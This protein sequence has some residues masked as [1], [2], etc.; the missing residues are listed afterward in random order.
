MSVYI[1]VDLR[2]RVRKADRDRCAYCLTVETISGISLSFDHI[3]PL[4]KGG[5]TDFE[6]LCLSCRSCNEFKVDITEAQD[7]LTG[8]VVNLFNPRTQQWREHF[9]WS[10]NG[11]IIEGKTAIGR[12]TVIVL[13]MNHATI[14]AARRFWTAV[15][16]HPPE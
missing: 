8:E 6:N 11:T 2:K 5:K 13:Q 14:V 4:S 12:A 10:A 15:G 9:N 7:T 1:S 16:C 3:H